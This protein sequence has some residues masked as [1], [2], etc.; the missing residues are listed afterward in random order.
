MSPP[1]N[2]Q[3]QS[4]A[5]AA[6]ARG[7]DRAFFEAPHAHPALILARVLAHVFDHA[8]NEY[9]ISA[10]AQFKALHDAA[11]A[12]IQDRARDPAAAYVTGQ[13]FADAIAEA[14]L[15]A[16]PEIDQPGA[17]LAAHA[18]ARAC[19]PSAARRPAGGAGQDPRDVGTNPG[20]SGDAA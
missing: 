16:V 12:I 20:P 14:L 6:I 15:D 17:I 7:V 1:F 10:P 13:H 11:V 9:E 5:F 8:H 2:T 3:P 19:A 18:F 4:L